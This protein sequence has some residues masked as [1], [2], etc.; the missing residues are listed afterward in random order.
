MRFT[1][2]LLMSL[3]IGLC[4]LLQMEQ[5]LQKRLSEKLQMGE[6]TPQN[7]QKQMG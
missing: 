6:L 4:K 1:R 7:R 5:R 2:V 3:L